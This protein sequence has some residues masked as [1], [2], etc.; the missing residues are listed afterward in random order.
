MVKFL[1]DN[2]IPAHDMLTRRNQH[3]RKIMN[4]PFTSESKMMIV[5]REIV[6]DDQNVRVYV[7]GA[8]EFIIPKCERFYDKQFHLSTFMNNEQEHIL[9]NLVNDMAQRGH[10]V[11]TYGY[12]E[13]STEDLQHLLEVYKE[14]LE[15]PG[16][17]QELMNDLI[18][19]ATFGLEDPIRNT[20]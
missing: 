9:D 6:N 20:V 12:R 4:I 1:I 15:N 8:P 19:L 5:I 2:D 17:K 16:F 7:K 18:Y 10:K 3:A 14:N 13:I 11:L